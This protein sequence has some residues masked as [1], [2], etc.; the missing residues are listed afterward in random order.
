MAQSWN[1]ENLPLLYKRRWDLKIEQFKMKNIFSTVSVSLKQLDVLWVASSSCLERRPV[2]PESVIQAG[3]SWWWCM[4]QSRA[5]SLFLFWNSL[6]WSSVVCQLVQ[7]GDG[8]DPTAFKYCNLP[9]H[10]ILLNT[11]PTYQRP[12]FLPF[13][14][15]RVTIS[16]TLK[17]LS[18]TLTDFLFLL[19][20]QHMLEANCIFI[21][22]SIAHLF[23]KSFRQ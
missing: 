15:S 9:L 4:I 19:L 12:F 21:I 13:C 1:K 3:E 11:V 16:P 10:Y 23:L 6:L 22:F 17:I 2:A 14:A 20:C 8:L 7:V 5:G 18:C